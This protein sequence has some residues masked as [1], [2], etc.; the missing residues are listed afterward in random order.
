MNEN[1]LKE[2]P[3]TE[4]NNPSVNSIIEIHEDL[5]CQTQNQNC[6]IIFDLLLK[7]IIINVDKALEDK[8]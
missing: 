3:C 2:N 4:R 5:K 1:N 8:F 6:P 7:D